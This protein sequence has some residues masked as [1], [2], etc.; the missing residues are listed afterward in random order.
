MIKYK[1]NSIRNHR[2]RL[3]NNMLSFILCF[4]C[5]CHFLD[6]KELN[7]W[8]F[9]F[10]WLFIISFLHF[11]NS[12]MYIFIMTTQIYFFKRKE[13]EKWYLLLYIITQNQINKT[14]KLKPKLKPKPPIFFPGTCP[15]S[16]F[17]ECL[18]T[19]MFQVLLHIKL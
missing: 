15:I 16:P 10:T 8:S 9:C 13:T 6:S 18:L 17:Y 2:L 3:H 14:K 5:S 1:H 12:K 11:L 4:K 19:I 7:Y